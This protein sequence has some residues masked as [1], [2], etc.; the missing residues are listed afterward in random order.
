MKKQKTTLLQTATARS[1]YRWRSGSTGEL[2]K[3]LKEV[4]ADRRS[5]IEQGFLP[6]IYEHNSKGF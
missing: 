5:Y 6:P 4:L 2:F 3:D 1:P